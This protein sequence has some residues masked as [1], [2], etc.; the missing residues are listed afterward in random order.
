MLKFL[1]RAALTLL[2]LYLVAV[3]GLYAFQRRMM[4]H[5]PT[6]ATSPAETGLPIQVVPLTTTDGEH[7]IAWW[8]PAQPGKPTLLYFGGNGDSLQTQENRWTRIAAAGVGFFA[9]NYRGYGGSSGHPTEAGLH[10]DAEA[11]YAW[12]SARIPPSEIVIHGF[13]LGTGV[14][15]KL[16]SDHP[17]RALILEAPYTATVDVAQTQFPWVPTHILMKDQF[18]S[19]DWIGKVRMPLL[20]IHGDADSVIAFHFGRELFSMAHQP[21]TF[22]EMVGS[23]HNTLARDGEYDHIWR[24]LDVPFQGSTAYQGAPVR[25]IVTGATDGR[26]QDQTDDRLGG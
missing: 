14:A 24:F 21:K 4:Y 5:P 6:A 11:A 17:A 16:A 13:S 3:A 22:V 12:L 10:A 7:L 8:L 18:R 1:K 23:D 19:R 26:S 20:V 9:I 25:A 2:A 15:S